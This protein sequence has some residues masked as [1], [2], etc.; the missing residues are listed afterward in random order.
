MGMLVIDI[1][2]PLI[3]RGFSE[4]EDYEEIIMNTVR[5]RDRNEAFAREF[6]QS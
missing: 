5:L 6:Y 2:V 4:D 1:I 3:I